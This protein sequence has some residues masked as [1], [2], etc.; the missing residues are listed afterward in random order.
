MTPAT[1]YL[2]LRP[3]VPGAPPG[4]D[5]ALYTMSG[6]MDKESDSPVSR[7]DSGSPCESRRRGDVT[8]LLSTGSPFRAVP[9]P[10]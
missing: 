6:Q 1:S 2:L 4:V 7:V 5:E 9:I 10:S 3:S 8:G